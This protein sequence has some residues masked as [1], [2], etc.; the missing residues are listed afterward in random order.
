MPCK[1]GANWA[2]IGLS[3]MQELYLFIITPKQQLHYTQMMRQNKIIDL[4]EPAELLMFMDIVL[5]DRYQLYHTQTL[6]Y[7]FRCFC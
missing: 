1:R 3:K 4:T 6:S 7:R 5:N 2:S